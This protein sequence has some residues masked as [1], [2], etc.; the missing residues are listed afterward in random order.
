MEYK[1]AY[2]F[3]ESHEHII[4]KIIELTGC[5]LYLELGVSKGN[6]MSAAS[7]YCEKCIGVDIQD[8]RDFKNFEFHLTS[9]D[10]F[11][12]YFDKKADI[13]FIDANHNFEQVKKD[14]ENSLK[15]L[16][17][18]G[19]IFLHDTDP[20]EKD[21]LTNDRCGDSYRIHEWIK[22]EY[23]EL[24]IITLP[25]GIAGLTMVNRNIDRRVLRFKK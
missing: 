3:N 5:K 8:I 15:C 17:E 11:F 25:I 24:N 14:F 22:N 21:L 2:N 12:K 10:E 4:S 13:I 16:N 9:T 18:F 23:K 1:F 19:I 20:Y 7:K 6:S